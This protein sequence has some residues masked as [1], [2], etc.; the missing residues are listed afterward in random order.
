MSFF[1]VLYTILIKPLQL[2]FEVGFV[3]ANKFIGQPGY[4]IV[5]LSL[6]MNFL[7]L[8]LYR[9]ADE[10]QQKERD[11][12][13]KLRD[14]V[15][16]IKKSFSGDERMM[17]LQTY[18]RQ[19]HYQPARAVL[20]S[21]SLFLQIPFFIAAYQFLSNLQALQGVAFGP[22]A[23]LGAP[24]ALLTIN[25]FSINLL[26]FLMTAVNIISGAIYLKGFPLKTKIQ[27]YALAVFFLVFLYASPAGL[28]FYWT[29]N[30]VF[31]LVKNCFYRFKN[32]LKVFS[33]LTS[34]AGLGVILFAVFGYDTPSLKRKAV[35]LTAGLLLQLP[36]VY[37][38]VI[39]KRKECLLTHRGEPNRKVFLLCAVF[40]AVLTGLLIP[41]SVLAASPQEFVETGVLD[42]PLWYLVS[43]F[44]IACGAFLVWC[45]IFYWLASPAGKLLFE[46]ALW[47]LCGITVL[48]YMFFGTDL[49]MLTSG[50]QYENGLNFD[51][52]RQA[53]NLGIIAAVAAVLFFIVSKWRRF[54]PGILLVFAIALSGMTG[55]NIVRITGSV[56]E[57]DVQAAKLSDD[58]P[59]FNLSKTGKN[60]IVLMLDR[61]LGHQVP[62]IFKEKPEIKRQ[63]EGFTYYSN[64]IS[65]G[66]FTNFGTPALF[67]GY[68]YTP[69][70]MNKRD[71]EPLV[72]KHNEAIMVLPVLYDSNGYEVTVI[73]P[74]YGN[75]K[76]QT[77]LSIYDDYPNIRKFRAN[78]VFSDES[79]TR[80]LIQNNHRN[81]FCF[82]ILKSA[83][84]F[85]QGLIYDGGNYNRTA[86]LSDRG[87]YTTQIQKSNTVAQGIRNSFMKAYNVLV[88]LPNITNISEDGINTFLMMANTATHEPM[89]LQEPDYEVS[90]HVDNTEYFAQDQ[91]RFTVDGRT[92][93][94]ENVDQI[95][96]YHTN[97]AT[98]KQ[99]GN[100][101]DYLR[102][103]GVY[104]NTKI[105]LVADHGR[106]LKQ[107]EDLILDDGSDKLKNIEFYYPLL[108][109]KDFNSRTFTQSDEFMT[110]ADVPTIALKDTVDKPVNPF[111]GKAIT[112]DAKTGEN[113]IIASYDWDVAK[114]GGNTFLPSYWLSVKDNI[115]NKSNWKFYGEKT[116]L[117]PGV[118]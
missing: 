21:L 96:H 54:L 12:Q 69:V 47:V 83:P 67:G 116:T 77:D 46:K 70:E 42:N 95:G 10:V 24:D 62:Y 72:D 58:K 27:T 104:D 43:S 75:Y 34:A 66:S 4:A 106:P 99:L 8:P 29:L 74:P 33:V 5:F 80:Q 40:L 28:V 25:G 22:V 107:I 85:L 84:L 59:S 86:T 78:G 14:G 88:N 1:S 105:I 20:G 63:F 38:F 98:L 103:N 57:L 87:K 50:L 30:N 114:N 37:A 100:W 7:V 52:T 44:S 73:D 17:I 117:P 15:A 3:L 13:A 110:N 90:L 97:L 23:D 92:L 53:V 31:S 91:D 113:Y 81:F 49:G 19:N 36:G 94:M 76:N 102:D 11:I 61:S 41:S 16:H 111:T 9:R 35:V 79:V 51:I 6:M 39:Q 118:E 115:W 2:L 26:P 64:T 82:G 45:S 112:N 68:E 18:Y 108:M 71:A 60:V 56:A 65:F 109:V 32:P 89:L 48:N 101:F 55:V 93:K